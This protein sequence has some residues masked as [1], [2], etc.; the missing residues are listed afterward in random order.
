[1]G[2]SRGAELLPFSGWAGLRAVGPL[3]PGDAESLE[4]SW[5]HGVDRAGCYGDNW[6]RLSL[7]TWREGQDG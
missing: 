3:D 2:G 1:M 5:H 6:E 7:D 4:S